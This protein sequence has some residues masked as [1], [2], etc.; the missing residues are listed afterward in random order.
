MDNARPRPR[1]RPR[2]WPGSKPRPQ[3]ELD[4]I[5]PT[6]TQTFT[7]TRRR[8]LFL[9]TITFMLYYTCRYT[10]LLY[11]RRVRAG[12]PARALGPED[13]STSRGD[14]IDRTETCPGERWLPCC[15]CRYHHCHRS[16][17][18]KCAIVGVPWRGSVSAKKKE[19]R[20]S[21]EALT[22][23]LFEPKKSR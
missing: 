14:W 6:E 20:N 19:A 22:A 11:G 16:G 1:P 2:R 21:F 13:R 3:P 12:G 10:L 7:Q 4:V 18:W 17:G 23:Y 15:H 9:L 8:V 5:E